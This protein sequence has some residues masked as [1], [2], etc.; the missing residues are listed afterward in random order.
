MAAA[1][2]HL[3]LVKA[4]IEFGADINRQGGTFN[5]TAINEAASQGQREVVE[6]LLSRH[7]DLDTSDPV[8]NP[9]FGAI[10][11]GNIEIVKLL[12]SFGI[13][14]TVRYSGQNMTNMDALDFAI[15]R[16]QTAIADFLRTLPE[17]RDPK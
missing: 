12:L 1:A 9:L 13:D 3:A 5:G 11:N 7:A 4:L 15:E 14:P 2:G 8:R 16:G 6:Y 10:Y 17:I